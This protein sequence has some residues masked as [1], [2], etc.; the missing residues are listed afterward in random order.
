M[1]EF[2]EQEARSM[3]QNQILSVVCEGL[4]EVAN[5]M[6]DEEPIDKG[7]YKRVKVKER[8]PTC[9][10]YRMVYRQ[11]GSH[12]KDFERQAEVFKSFSKI[13]SIREEEKKDGKSRR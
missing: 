3:T 10:K 6:A 9:H 5:K 1:K 4:A 11:K 13:F 12:K 2:S 8:C 7:E